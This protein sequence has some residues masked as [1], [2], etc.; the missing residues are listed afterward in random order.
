[1]KKISKVFKKNKLIW[2]TYSTIANV[3]AY[4][5]SLISPERS[6]KRQ[7]KSA[8]GKKLDLTN[9]QTLNEKLM[10]LKLTKYWH[11]PLVTQCADKYLVREYIESKGCGEIL[12][13]ILGHWDK[14][15]D[16]DWNSL[17]Q[18]FA[19]KCNH[20]SGYN[21]ICTNKEDFDT[22]EATKSLNRWM[23]KRYGVNYTEQ[24]IYDNIPRCIIAEEFIETKDGLP[25]KDYKFFCSYGKCKFL[26]VASD[27][28]D[29]NT[30][31]DYYYPDWTYI[32]VKNFFDNNGPVA[33]PAAL[34]KMIEYAEKLSA[35]F[36]IVRID[37]YNEGE[38]IVFGEI[39]FTH[40]GCMN[41]FEPESYDLTFGSFFPNAEELSTWMQ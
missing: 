17:P 35:D 14:A 37:L 8:F 10:Y 26:F 21:L 18:K 5:L 27:R 13:G 30:K 15:E 4:T 23:H 20:G 12:N 19:I 11:N 24:G 41:K 39:T 29:N 16:I 34:E 31:F 6:S 1:M 28:Y 33:K 36:P 7:Y 22:K 25:P 38:R 2:K 32:P 3:Y 9:P 40:F